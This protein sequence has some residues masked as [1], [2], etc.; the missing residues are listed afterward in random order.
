MKD[1][2]FYTRWGHKAMKRFVY[3]YYHDM[4]LRRESQIAEPMGK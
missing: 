4:M 2:D 3:D 1:Y